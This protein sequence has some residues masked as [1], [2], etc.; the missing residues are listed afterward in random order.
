[1]AGTTAEPVHSMAHSQQIPLSSKIER[2]MGLLFVLP[3]VLLLLSLGLFPLFYSLGVSFLRWDLQNQVQE[4]VGLKN[5]L[6]VLADARMWNALKNTVFFM[7]FGV[8]FELVFGLALAQTLVGHL[9]GKRFI[10]PLLILPAVAAPI[11]VGFTW[12]MMYDATYGPIDYLLTRLFGQPINIVWLVN[13]RAVYPAV[14]LTEIWQWTP[15]MFLIMLAA[16]TA[17][18]PELQEAAIM[19]GAT[20]WQV[21]TRIT[22]P[23]IRPVIIVAVLFRA[24]DLFK[25]FDIIL[26]LTG[27][28]PGNMTETASYYMYIL[29]FRNF[30]LGYTA[31][32]SYVMLIFFSILLTVMLR[33]LQEEN[34]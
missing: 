30:R 29:G 4:F 33:R 34:E 28:G 10:V 31:A 23:T 21:F 9:P 15:F 6:D 19:D 24:L 32:M 5:Y 27:G 18:N 8:L 11:V 17:L 1:M 26:P 7:F 2:R 22:L 3:A 12:R 16:L 20:R 13:L 14:L 25:L